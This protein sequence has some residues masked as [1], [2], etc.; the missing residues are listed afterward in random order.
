[1]ELS[2]YAFVSLY[3]TRP[4]DSQA[5]RAAHG[6]SRH[7]RRPQDDRPVWFRPYCRAYHAFEASIRLVGSTRRAV[8]RSRRCAQHR[9]L[10]A[11]RHLRHASIRLSGAS[12]RMLRAMGEL[13][14]TR[15]CVTGDPE[16]S[17]ALASLLSIANERWGEIIGWLHQAA[18]D[19]VTLQEDVV[20]GL[21]SGRL[22]AERPAEHR[23]RIRLTPCPVPFRAFLLLRQPR[24]IDR[25]TPILRRRR[26]TPRPASVRVPRR[27]LRGRAPPL[28]PISVP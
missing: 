3:V 23:P 5:T 20:L 19:V 27:C 22:V 11:S 1:M 18:V 8:A 21:E 25:I 17:E 13:A 4:N 14:E 28:F 9:P 15:A 16:R 26:R 6:P 12:R 7:R 2:F 10:R 24:V